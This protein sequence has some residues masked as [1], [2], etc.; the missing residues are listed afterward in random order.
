MALMGDPGRNVYLIGPMGSGKTS[1]GQRAAK[2]L[3][4]EFIDCDHELEAQTGASVNLIFDIEGEE[5]FRERESRLLEQIAA[6]RGALVATGGGVVLRDRNRRLLRDSGLVVYI[7]ASVNQQLHRLGRDRARPLL[8]TGDRR[9]K[10]ADLAKQRNPLYER[11]ADIEF[12][13]RSRNLEATARS[14]AELIRTQRSGQR[15]DLTESQQKA[16]Q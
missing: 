4:L 3:G 14:L 2:I 7:S 9:A 10:L 15:E 13:S 16:A 5:G 6:R 12:Q 1:L 8:Q 11:V